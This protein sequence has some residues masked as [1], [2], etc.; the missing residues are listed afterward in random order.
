MGK[1]N[2]RGIAGHEYATNLLERY[3]KRFGDR[4]LVTKYGLDN[5]I[6]DVFDLNSKVL[7]D[8]KFG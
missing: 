3:F 4:G 7:Y 6:A 1:G 8:W 2:V 5:G